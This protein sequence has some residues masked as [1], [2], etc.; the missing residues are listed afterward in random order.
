MTMLR[1]NRS[2]LIDDWFDHVKLKHSGDEQSGYHYIQV[3]DLQQGQY[4]LSFLS[5]H[6]QL[7][8]DITVHKG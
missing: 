7:T 5:G 2:M 1:Y 3:D 4:E 8:F 6:G